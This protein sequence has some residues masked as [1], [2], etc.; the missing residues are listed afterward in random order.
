MSILKADLSLFQNIVGWDFKENFFPVLSEFGEINVHYV[1]ENK[2]AEE[3]VLL[4]HGNPT[5]GY[6]YRNM[7]NPLKE[8]G[9]RVIVP[10]LP[11]FG[12]SDKFSIRYNYTYEGFVDWMSQFVIGLDIKN[13]TLFCQ[14]WGG[15]KGL[16]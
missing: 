10:D 4:M 8:S 15:L 12:K 7:I 14:D 16:R 3:V 2:D 13:I 5:W 1:D 11:G 6:L 9:Y